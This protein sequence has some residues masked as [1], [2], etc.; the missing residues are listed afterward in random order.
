MGPHRRSISPGRAGQVQQ[1]TANVPATFQGGSNPAALA[2]SSI[3][4]NECKLIE[5][6][7]A[8]DQSAQKAGSSPSPSKFFYRFPYEVG[9]KKDLPGQVNKVA[10]PR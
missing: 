6:G 2:Q 3:T 7:W 5:R 8:Q 1:A 9:S 4:S 10:D